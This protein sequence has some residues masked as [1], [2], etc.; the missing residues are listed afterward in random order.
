MN[1]EQSSQVQA[2]Y[3][4]ELPA[5]ERAAVERHLAECGSC[6]ELLSDLRAM[7]LEM[8]KVSR[9]A[10]SADARRR[11][12]QAWW[13]ARDRGVLHLAEWLTAAA[14]A[15][16]VGALLFWS[17]T[18]AHANRM[19]EAPGGNGMNVQAMNVQM[20]SEQTDVMLPPVE[21]RDEVASNE[22]DLAE[23]IASD[24]SVDPAH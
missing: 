5:G 15:I 22:V 3:D 17:D 8:A 11:L 1:C 23:W 7:S 20:P 4:N 16:L 18:G 9:P 6:S 2:Y 21:A 19:A 14:A 12:E 24:L 13:A 10:M